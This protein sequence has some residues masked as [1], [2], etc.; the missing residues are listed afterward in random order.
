MA[1]DSIAPFLSVVVRTQGSRPGSLRDVLLCLLGQ[2]SVDFELVLVAHRS[3]PGPKGRGAA[4]AR[5]LPSGLR[6]RTRVLDVEGG[7]RSRPVN[8]G[9]EVA[10]AGTLAALD[11]DDLVL[12][13]WVETFAR[14][15][16]EAAGRVVRAGCVEQDVVPEDVAGR[17]GAAHGRAAAA[18]VPPD[19][20]PGR[21][22]GA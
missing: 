3:R 14:A 11:D 15:E 7:G 20:R 22:P 16:Q 8:I 13:H 4:G 1:D 5:R 19:V 10:A 9:L 18:G 21:A 2:T 17:P 12:A 6:G